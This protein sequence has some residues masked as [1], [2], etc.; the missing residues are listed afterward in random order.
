MDHAVYRKDLVPQSFDCLNSTPF[1][2]IVVV[3]VILFLLI[4]ILLV[5]ISSHLHFH[6]LCAALFTAIALSFSG[7]V[8]FLSLFRDLS[9]QDYAVQELQALLVEGGARK[10]RSESP[11]SARMTAGTGDKSGTQTLQGSRT[12]RAISN[13]IDALNQSYTKAKDECCVQ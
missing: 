10:G 5:F 6:H 2:F 8:V 7:A 11:G 9:E 12:P 13:P 1:I 4:L 3:I